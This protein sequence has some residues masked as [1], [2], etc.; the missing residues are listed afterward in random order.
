MRGLLSGQVM[1][2]TTITIDVSFNAITKLYDTSKEYGL[3]CGSYTAKVTAEA[4]RLDRVGRVIGSNAIK[5]SLEEWVSKAWNNSVILNAEDAESIKAIRRLKK[6]SIYL[7]TCNP[8]AENMANYLLRNVTPRVLKA[9][10]VRVVKVIIYTPNG[11][12]SESKI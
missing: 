11:F 1:V 5:D 12:Y 9:V 4:L 6:S 3:T 10:N 7:L 2:S 8:T